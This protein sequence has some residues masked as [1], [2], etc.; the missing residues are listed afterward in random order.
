MT[1]TA[2]RQQGLTQKYEHTFMHGGTA[3][4]ALI[5]DDSLDDVDLFDPNVP[6]LSAIQRVVRAVEAAPK[7]VAVSV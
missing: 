7:H 3:H 5:L 1:R 6:D 2:Q 4:A